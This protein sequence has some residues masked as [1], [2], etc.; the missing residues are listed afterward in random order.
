MHGL[1]L[2]DKIF[3]LSVFRTPISIKLMLRAFG[4]SQILFRNSANVKYEEKLFFYFIYI[5]I[6]ERLAM[7][8]SNLNLNLYTYCGKGK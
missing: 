5:V 6:F 4:N 8:L 2:T 1:R 7:A 3:R